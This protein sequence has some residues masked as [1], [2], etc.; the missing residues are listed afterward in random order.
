M[1]DHIM[2]SDPYWG[3]SPYPW[4]DD[5]DGSDAWRETECRRCGKGGLTWEDDNGRWRLVDSH[6]EV[7]H[8]DPVKIAKL[9][10]SDFESP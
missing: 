4:Q 10:A 1:A 8:C 5:E 6:G 2:N 7:H 3:E 9:V